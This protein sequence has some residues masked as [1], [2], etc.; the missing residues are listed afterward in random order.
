MT[1]YKHVLYLM[2]ILCVSRKHTREGVVRKGMV[3]KDVVTVL[4][5]ISMP[6]SSSA[7]EGGSSDD[8]AESAT[9]EEE[10]ET[11]QSEGGEDSE[12]EEDE[13]EASGQE[14]EVDSKRRKSSGAGGLVGKRNWDAE[15]K[16]RVQLEKGVGG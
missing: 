9:S 5:G 6:S 10:A 16:R 14:R 4:A 2:S 3:E 11:V 12:E 15:R 7:W 13:E 1:L 8:F